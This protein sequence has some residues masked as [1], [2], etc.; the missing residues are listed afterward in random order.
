MGK[1]AQFQIDPNLVKVFVKVWNKHYSYRKV[2][3]W[4]INSGWCYQFAVLVR[5]VYGDKVKIYSDMD[6]GHCWVKVG[7]LFYDSDHLEGVKHSLTMSRNPHSKNISMKQVC[8]IWEKRGASGPVDLEV[9]EL[10]LK[11]YKKRK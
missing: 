4:Y 7:T 8:E 1:R 6:G 10:A 3:H 9:I 2:E 5:R 11:T